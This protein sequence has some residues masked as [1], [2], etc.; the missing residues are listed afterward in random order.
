MKKSSYTRVL[1]LL[2]LAVLLTVGIAGAASTNTSLNEPDQ[3]NTYYIDKNTYYIDIF[4]EKCAAFID[5]TAQSWLKNSTK[6]PDIQKGIRDYSDML[7][8]AKGFYQVFLSKHGSIDT[9]ESLRKEKQKYE[10]LIKKIETKIKELKKSAIPIEPLGYM[11]DDN[12]SGWQKYLTGAD[13]DG[14][15]CPYF[16][17]RYP[18]SKLMSEKGKRELAIFNYVVFGVLLAAWGGSLYYY[19]KILPDAIAAAA[20]ASAQYAEQTQ[21]TQYGLFL[22]EEALQ[23]YYTYRYKSV[24]DELIHNPADESS[25]YYDLYHP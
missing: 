6:Q 4:H 7:Q 12:L 5:E 8:R 16:D 20:K 21:Q 23:Y 25:I 22:D 3:E 1:T 11:D 17:D 15:D 14:I 19:G 10:T 9:I 18:I 13:I 24:F 2:L